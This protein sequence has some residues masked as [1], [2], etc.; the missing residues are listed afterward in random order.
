MQLQ[1][2]NTTNNT[3]L[4]ISCQFNPGKPVREHQAILDFSAARY[5]KRQCYL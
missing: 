1:L 4:A 3:R 2:L 5:V